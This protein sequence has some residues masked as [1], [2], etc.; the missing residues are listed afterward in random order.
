MRYTK[1]AADVIDVSSWAQARNW[2]NEIL[3]F[4]T[5]S[6]IRTNYGPRE[7]ETSRRSRKN[8]AY[9]ITSIC[10]ET[11]HRLAEIQLEDSDEIS[12]L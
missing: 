8:K 9:D 1:A 4:L 6:N 3:Y 11:R 10:V 2:T 5:R 12:V 7:A